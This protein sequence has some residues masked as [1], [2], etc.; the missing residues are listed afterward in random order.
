MIKG[1][2]GG[3]A[4]LIVGLGAAPARADDVEPRLAVGGSLGIWIPTSDADDFADVSLGVRPQVTYWIRPFIGVTGAFDFVFVN[5]DSGVGDVTYYAISAGAR[6]TLPRGQIRPY[7]ELLL[8][9]H[10]IDT[11]GF[12]DNE[13]GLRLGGGATYTLS[14]G[15]IANAGISY[16]T[17]SFDIGFGSITVA[18]FVLDLGI[19]ARF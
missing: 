15:L 5:E 19:A 2:I 6:A 13:F 18:A 10:F 16:S 11:N 17:T 4:A 1:W 14:S 8:G 9:V 12:D 3:V 7:G